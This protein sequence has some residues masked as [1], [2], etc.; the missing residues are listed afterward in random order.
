MTN[1]LSSEGLHMYETRRISLLKKTH[2]EDCKKFSA[3]MLKEG[4]SYVDEICVQM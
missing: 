2:L 4:D 1:T 3:G